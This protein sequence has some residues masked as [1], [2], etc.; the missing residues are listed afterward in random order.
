MLEKFAAIVFLLQTH[1]LITAI[2]RFEDFRVSE[3]FKGAP[4]KPL[5][6]TRFARL[7]RTNIR[8]AAKGGPNFAGHFTIVE[9]GCGSDCGGMA[10][11]DEQT[12]RVYESPSGVIAFPPYLDYP[13]ENNAPAL[14]FKL[15][16]RLFV[17]HGCPGEMGCGSY[18]YEWTGSRF[19]LLRELPAIE[20]KY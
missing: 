6:Q 12:G 7:Y 18:Y 10:V 19:K 8:V 13:D 15:N 16:S 11:I 4:A 9:W 3:I 2:P 14:A 5:L 20:R 1:P 17:I